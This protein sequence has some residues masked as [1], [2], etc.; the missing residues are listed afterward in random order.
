LARTI[1]FICF[2]ENKNNFHLIT[3]KAR[4]ASLFSYIM[5]FS[6]LT[7][8]QKCAIIYLEHAIVAVRSTSYLG[9]TQEAKK[10]GAVS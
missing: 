7:K 9:T 3:I 1:P 8:G 2:K 10:K 4:T 5:N 6:P